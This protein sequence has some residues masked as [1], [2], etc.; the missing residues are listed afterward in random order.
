MVLDQGASSSQQ[1]EAAEPVPVSWPKFKARRLLMGSRGIAGLGP[2]KSAYPLNEKL[3]AGQFGTVWASRLGGHE[4]AVKVYKE[5]S[6]A[7]AVFEASLAERL[8]HPNVVRLLDCCLDGKVCYLVYERAGVSLASCLCQEFPQSVPGHP[9]TTGFVASAMRG[10]LECVAC[11]HTQG[12][13]HGDIKPQNLMV[14]SCQGAH[15][16]RFVVGDVGSAIE[17]GTCPHTPIRLEGAVT[18]LWYRSPELL[19]GQN[20]ANSDTWL[21]AD[22]WALGIVLFEILGFSFHKVNPGAGAVLRLG[23][24]LE[25][26][27][28]NGLGSGAPIR[29]QVSARP[30]EDRIG[31]A[32]TDLLTKLTAWAARDRPTSASCRCHPFVNPGCLRGVGNGEALPGCRHSWRFLSGCMEAELLCWLRA[33]AEESLPGWKADAM[34]SE[35]VAGTASTKYVL[36]GRVS[37]QCFSKSV[38]DMD[39]SRMLPAHR[40]C[41]FVRA[42][43]AVNKPLVLEMV[44]K[45]QKSLERISETEDIGKNGSF[46]L[47]RSASEWFLVVAEIHIIEGPRGIAE[48]RHVDGAAGCLTMGV[49]LFGH[50]D[51]RIW[52]RAKDEE[53]KA[54]E[55]DEPSHVAGLAPG[56]VYLS[57][58]AGPEHQAAHADVQDSLLCGH[59]VTLVVRTSLFPYNQSRG[60]KRVA[61]PA[62]TFRAVMDGIVA[63]L[64]NAWRLPALSDCLAH[65]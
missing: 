54:D 47:G 16:R 14:A 36:S 27:L 35:C 50:R 51:L 42:F 1:A 45:L 38:N 31:W 6:F 25:E 33:E 39:V 29:L 32:G 41:A 12:I 23:R 65:L 15:G 2:Q 52:P 49:T 22:V 18:T 30:M 5:A 57:T 59:S 48:R 56:S 53:E 4:L 10:F 19:A 24:A 43:T 13:F 64:A 28:G 9:P 40:L 21:R 61:H 11:L 44:A 20:C 55:L 63:S 62:V 34:A 26:S 46:V 17:V 7:D 3:G 37:D 58:L 60:M 8:D